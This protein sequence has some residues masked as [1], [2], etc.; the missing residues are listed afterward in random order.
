M[1]KQAVLAL[2]LTLIAS[3]FASA[4][5]PGGFDLSSGYTTTQAPN[6]FSNQ[7]NLQAVQAQQS[8]YYQA[9]STQATSSSNSDSSANSSGNYFDNAGI[10]TAGAQGATNRTS[11]LT[12]FGPNGYGKND[13]QYTTQ[14]KPS[15]NQ[16][17]GQTSTLQAVGTM[18]L[19][20]VFGYGGG[21][22]GLQSPGGYVPGIS[23]P[24]G[25]IGI[26]N[27]FNLPGGGLM[28]VPLP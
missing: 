22:G 8:S 18:G 25:N 16:V 10:A 23:T 14:Q 9:P 20:P 15:Y 27:T 24:F 7:Q 2:G 13:S 6:E 17:T 19:A 4:Q 11:N 28:Q 3:P 5:V 26:P 1:I 21:S 12:G